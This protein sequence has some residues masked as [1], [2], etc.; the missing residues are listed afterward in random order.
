MIVKWASEFPAACGS[1]CIISGNSQFSFSASV[2][3]STSLNYIGR[4]DNL[5]LTMTVV[6]VVVLDGVMVLVVDVALT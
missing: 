2:K 1:A 4:N 5:D 3:M 6:V